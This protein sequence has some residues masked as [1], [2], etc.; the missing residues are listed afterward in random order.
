MISIVILLL[1][2]LFL[3]LVISN[4]LTEL[5]ELKDKNTFLKEKS[6][7]LV[8]NNYLL[9]NDVD[10]YEHLVKDVLLVAT[11]STLNHEKVAIEKIKELIHD[12]QSKS[13][14]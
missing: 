13:T 6:E 1:I 10:D 4:L 8:D 5:Q 7:I 9:I 12:Y 2:I 3:F 11:N 14:Q